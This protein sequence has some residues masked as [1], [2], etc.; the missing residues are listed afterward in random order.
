MAGVIRRKRERSVATVPFAY[1]PE[2]GPGDPN[3]RVGTWLR[4]SS[5]APG[6][7][8]ARLADGLT[9]ELALEIAGRRWDGSARDS[10]FVSVS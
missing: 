3:V 8:R 9:S 2:G 1:L 5:I 7:G 10:A 6:L 4:W